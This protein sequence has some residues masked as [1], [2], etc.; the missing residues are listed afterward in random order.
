MS[1]EQRG[2]GQS[3]GDRLH[4]A[5]DYTSGPLHQLLQSFLTEHEAVSFPMMHVSP[6]SSSGSPLFKNVCDTSSL[7]NLSPSS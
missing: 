5:A 6:R 4:L 7:R 1:Q 2:C 3:P